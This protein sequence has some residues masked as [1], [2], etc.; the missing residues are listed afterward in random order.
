MRFSF[1]LGFD[2]A[3]HDEL[4]VWRRVYL[5]RYMRCQ[6]S[7]IERMTVREVNDHLRKL[8]ELIRAESP[9]TGVSDSVG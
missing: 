4:R 6:S 5:G 2:F 8:S 3:E 9:S 7:E 1:G